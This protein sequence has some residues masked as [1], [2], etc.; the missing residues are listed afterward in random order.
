MLN[1]IHG[2]KTFPKANSGIY[3]HTTFQ[4][5]NWP[6]KGFE[7]QVN[8][9]HTDPKKTGGLYAVK[10][11]MNTAPVGDNEWFTYDII[12][13]GNHVQLQINGK[14]TAD[15]TQP[16]DW[17]HDEFAGRRLAV[18]SRRRQFRRAAWQR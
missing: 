17:K 13:K 5:S 7:A 8:A 18:T 15:W 14:T 3:F 12:V 9:T 6:D 10:D 16:A 2:V 1:E 11:V 4:E